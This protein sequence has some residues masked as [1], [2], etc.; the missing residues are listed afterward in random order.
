[1]GN[2]QGKKKLKVSEEEENLQEVFMLKKR[3]Y[4]YYEK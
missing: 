3:H 1:M 4:P 2:H